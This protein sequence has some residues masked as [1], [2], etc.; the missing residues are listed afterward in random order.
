MRYEHIV[1]GTF[2]ERPN[3]FIARVEIEGHV[4]TVHVKNTGRCKELL[5]PGAR[6]YLEQSRNPNRSTAYDLI[7]VEK[8]GRVINMDSQATNKVVEEWLRGK[9]LFSGA[10]DY[11]SNITSV[12]PETFYGQSRFDFYV[13]TPEEKIFIEVKGVTLEEE[14]VVRF[15]DAPS[16]RAIKHMEELVEARRKG[17]RAMVIF[18]IQMEGVK[19]FTPNRDTHAAFG[20]ALEAAQQAGVEVYAFDCKVTP[21]T[22]EINRPVPVSMWPVYEILRKG[23]LEMI[24]NPLLKWYDSNKRILPWRQDPT[25][26]HVWV[27]E[28]MLQQTRVEAVKPY[29][30]RFMSALP[31]IKSLAKAPEEK[32]L[33]LWEGLGYYNRVRNLQ[34]AAIQIM[35]HYGGEMPGDYEQLLKLKGIGS[36]TAGAIASIAF[37]KPHVA[38]DGNVLRVLSRYRM[39]ER[40]ISLQQV[41]TAVEQELEQVIPTDRPGDFNQAM[42][43]L[44]ACVCVPNG[45]PHCEQ[46]P[47]REGCMAHLQGIELQYP[48]KAA[49]KGRSVEYK[50]I[51]VL[52]DENRVALRKRPGKGLLAGMYEFPWLEGHC[53]PE[54]VLEYLT[55]RGM[56]SI[57]ITPLIEAKHIFT[58]K[59]WHMTGY[60]VR[61]DE[62]ERTEGPKEAGSGPETWLYVEPEETRERYPIPAAF[63]AYAKYLNIPLGIAAEQEPKEK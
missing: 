47:L 33:K 51:L 9:A 48:R 11:I 52:Q 61:V 5:L 23:E 25:P 22:L 30:K 31:D 58:H 43:E 53:T 42:M 37:G 15:P 12:K 36:Y 14:G 2:I 26:Y 54:Q 59:E 32:L 16:E 21:E 6:V 3:R 19:Y 1:P 40:E 18:V 45:A 17:Y 62:L 4:E 28:I 50:T 13:E 44:G 49:A 8:N 39:D 46:C 24:P 34:A 38:V 20:D 7:A 41:K 63:G 56:K 35:E 10:S 29:Y 55:E 60:L 57:R 27:S